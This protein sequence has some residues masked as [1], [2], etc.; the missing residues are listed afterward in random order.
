MAKRGTKSVTDSVLASELGVTQA[1]LQGYRGRELTPK[2]VANLLDRAAKKAS[3]ELAHNSIVPIVEFLPI[4][5]AETAQGKSWLIFAHRE[6]D[7]SPHPFWAGLRQALEQSHGIYIFHDSRG[8]AIYV[9]KAHLLSLWTEL[10]NAFNRDRGEVQSIKR[11]THPSTRKSFKSAVEIKRQVTK[12]TV[13]L[14]HIAFYLSAYSVPEPLIGKLEALL[15]RGF[16]N[17]LLNVR[18]EHF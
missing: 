2:Q 5:A 16:A 4:T 10:N 7:G 14:H 9:G 11:V 12:E 6:E 3:D 1:A 18:M 15:V 17:D 8:R 13:P